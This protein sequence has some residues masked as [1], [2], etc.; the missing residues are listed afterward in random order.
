MVFTQ[1]Q[2]N[3]NFKTILQNL[4]VEWKG[5]GD[6]TWRYQQIAQRR[7]CCRLPRQE[8]SEQ[9]RRQTWCWPPHRVTDV[10]CLLYIAPHHEKRCW[11]TRRACANRAWPQQGCSG[12]A[13]WAFGRFVP[14]SQPMAEVPLSAWLCPPWSISCPPC[15]VLPTADL[16]Y[17]H[18]W[19][20]WLRVKHQL[21]GSCGKIEKVCRVVCP[22]SG[23][24][25]GPQAWP[26]EIE[27]VLPE[28]ATL[29]GPGLGVE[30]QQNPS[31]KENYSSQGKLCVSG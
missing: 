11:G 30:M 15:S 14:C 27:K 2:S 23:R 9:E 8:G 31:V 19:D 20:W 18:C 17:L 13:E 22:L 25:N 10:F 24:S 7:R 29:F 21:R 5:K 12:S 3:P 16:C 4:R 26:T 6:M 1:V 28:S